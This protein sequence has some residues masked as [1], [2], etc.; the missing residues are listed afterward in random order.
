MYV[1]K[2]NVL[3]QYVDAQGDAG[4]N[5]HLVDASVAEIARK[6]LLRLT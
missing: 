3:T 2:H 1:A 4:N 5:D 6:V